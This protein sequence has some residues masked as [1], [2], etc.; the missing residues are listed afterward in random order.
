MITDNAISGLNE[1]CLRDRNIE[2]T[3]TIKFLGIRLDD[4]LTFQNHISYISSKVSRA[5]G[6]I[7]RITYLVPFPQLLNLY[8]TMIYP[9][10]LY[11][12]TVWGK[13]SIGGE[14]RLQRLQKR[15]IKVIVKYERNPRP[16]ITRLLTIESIYSYFTLR[17][18]FKTLKEHNHQYFRNRLLDVQTVHKYSTRF[19]TH[20]G[21]N[22]PLFTKTKCL[23][24]FAYQ[25]VS[26]WNKIPYSIRSLPSH[27]NFCRDLKQYLI[28]N[29]CEIL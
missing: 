13:S 9:H 7:N 21:L 2:R 6:I 15:A 8:Y 19:K 17:K 18:L 3:N 1:I 5:I 10:F 20:L 23:A 24:S 16:E 4:K 12:I 25:S 29:Q 11:G 26:I 28:D 27:K 22:I 14:T